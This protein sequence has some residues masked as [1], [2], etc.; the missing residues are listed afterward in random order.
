[1]IFSIPISENSSEGGAPSV[2]IT[3]SQSSTPSQGSTPVQGAAPAPRPMSLN[4]SSSPEV[5]TSTLHTCAASG[6]VTQLRKL[7]LEEKIAVYT[8]TPDG[9]SALHCAA[10]AGSQ[11]LYSH[12][13]QG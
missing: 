6:D 1:M 8:T 5:R 3:P 7:L 13:D 9:T 10:E 12:V 2:A 4:V 11:G